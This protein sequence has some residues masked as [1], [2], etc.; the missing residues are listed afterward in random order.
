MIDEFR[1]DVKAFKVANDWDADLVVFVVDELRAQGEDALWCYVDNE[2]E[3]TCKICWVS[4]EW[5]ADLKVAF[6]DHE[7]EAG[8]KGAYNMQG[9]L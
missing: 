9:R 2:W 6:T 5:E 8:W 3:A 7:W 4:H 1:A